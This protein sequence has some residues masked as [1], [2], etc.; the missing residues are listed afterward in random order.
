MKRE[1]HSRRWLR[2]AIRAIVLIALL[3]WPNG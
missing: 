2:L 3:L 1:P